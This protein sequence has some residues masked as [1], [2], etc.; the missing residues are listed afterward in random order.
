[1]DSK[2][3]EIWKTKNIWSIEFYKSGNMAGQAALKSAILINGG[4]AVALL[5][6]IGG[7][8]NASQNCEII[9]Q[10]SNA[11]FYFVAGVLIGAIATGIVYIGQFVIAYEK[12]RL[13]LILNFFSWALVISCYI[14]FLA[15]VIIAFKVF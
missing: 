6:F 11:M 2:E 5:A 8:F 9:T 15:G 13:S 10:L 14:L 1:M 12:F 7:I 3:W 4:A